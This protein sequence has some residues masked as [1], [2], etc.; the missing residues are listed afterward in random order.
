MDCWRAGESGGGGVMHPVIPLKIDRI[1][2]EPDT[3]R[4]H[5]CARL[6]RIVERWQRL[7]GEDAETARGKVLDRILEAGTLMVEREVAE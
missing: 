6:D 1:T 5:D 4:V 3:I 2:L 7:F